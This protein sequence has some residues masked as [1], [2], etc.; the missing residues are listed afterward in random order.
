MKKGGIGIRRGDRR[1]PGL[2]L[3][4]LAIAASF[5]GFSAV[6][7]L[8]SDSTGLN[9]NISSYSG[10]ASPAR[11]GGGSYLQIY[12]ARSFYCQTPNTH[13]GVCGCPSGY[14]AQLVSYAEGPSC[15]YDICW[16]SYGYICEN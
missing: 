9:G 12:R 13:T 1:R 7:S 15:D 2:I 11:G 8:S 14:S 4:C 3:V 16:A 6:E 5:F 10:Q